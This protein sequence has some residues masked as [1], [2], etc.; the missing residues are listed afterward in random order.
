M[1]GEI[2][3]CIGR[4]GRCKI[5]AVHERTVALHTGLYAEERKLDRVGDFTVTDFAVLVVGLREVGAFVVRVYEFILE[6]HCGVEE[7]RITD[8]GVSEYRVVGIGVSGVVVEAVCALYAECISPGLGPVP[9]FCKRVLF[10]FV[11]AVMETCRNGEFPD[12]VKFD[13]AAVGDDFFVNGVGRFLE[14]ALGE[15]QRVEQYLVACI[16]GVFQREEV[17]LEERLALPE[18]PCKDG[19][20]VHGVHGDVPAGERDARGVAPESKVR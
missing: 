14:G 10:D 13:T 20:D 8:R 9:D 11:R 18:T 17:H 5:H 4:I 6:M 16:V 15:V 7:C 12:G 3:R 19:L 2:E 1:E